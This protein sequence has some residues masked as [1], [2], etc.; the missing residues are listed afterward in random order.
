MVTASIIQSLLLQHFKAHGMLICKQ[1]VSKYHID[2]WYVTCLHYW[3]PWRA[4]SNP[5]ETDELS[6]LSIW[7]CFIGMPRCESADSN[8]LPPATTKATK[9]RKAERISK[10]LFCWSH[11]ILLIFR[12]NSVSKRKTDSFDLLNLK[13]WQQN[14]QCLNINHASIIS[15]LILMKPWNDL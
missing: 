2:M 12:F 7:H 5:L 13:L 6:G 14:H 3:N 9:K 10:E 8:S 15:Q 11:P 4:P 1:Y